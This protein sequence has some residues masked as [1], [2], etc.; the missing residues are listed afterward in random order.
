MAE[1]VTAFK[2]TWFRSPKVAASAG[3]AGAGRLALV[4]MDNGRD[5]TRPN[6]LGPGAL[7]SLEAALDA[8]EAQPDTRGLLLTGKPHSFAAGADLEVLAGATAALARDG[9]RRGQALFG[10]LRQ[11]P[12]PTLA[13][14]NGACLGGGLELALHC[15]WRTVSATAGPIAFPEVFLSI[16]P[17]WGGTQ[18]APRVV[19]AANALS[20]IVHNPL[21]SNRMLRPAQAVELGF[22]DRL[23]DPG[24]FLDRSL[25]LLESIAAGEAPL[26]RSPPP[27][28]WLDEA[29]AAA[30]R[31]AAERVH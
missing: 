28:A 19:G 3:E 31:V 6:T 16:V 26:R 9:A 22:A 17:G 1:G 13:A 14:V 30:R 11:L 4:T 21:A 10:R 27:A 7:A 12:F 2:V 8:V 5:H 18:L 23:L 24:D 15:D 29:L 25:A 20:A